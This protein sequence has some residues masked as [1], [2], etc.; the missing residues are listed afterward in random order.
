MMRVAGRFASTRLVALP[1][2]GIGGGALLGWTAAA[3][4]QCRT[5]TLGCPFSMM[6]APPAPDDPADVRAIAGDDKSNARGRCL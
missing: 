6:V 2:G 4:L 1:T 3:A 5:R